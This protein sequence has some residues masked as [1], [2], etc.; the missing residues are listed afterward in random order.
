M[1][2]SNPWSETPSHSVYIPSDT[3]SLK[4]RVNFLM[5]MVKK[6]AQEIN[7]LMFE[8]ETCNKELMKD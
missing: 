4:N 1:A 7:N 5:S 6:K 3:S 8:I 2:D